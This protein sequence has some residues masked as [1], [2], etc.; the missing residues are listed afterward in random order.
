M[1]FPDRAGEPELVVCGDTVAARRDEAVAAFGFGDGDRRLAARR[2][3][4]PDVDVVVVTAPNMLHV[5]IVEAAV[6]RRQARLLREAGRRHAGA[7][8]ARPQ[9]PPAPPA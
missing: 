3:T 7:D 9:R 6:R 4:H 1:L 5:E 8:R 2:A